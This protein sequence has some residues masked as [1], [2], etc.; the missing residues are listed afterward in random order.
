MAQDET[1]GLGSGPGTEPG[2]AWEPEDIGL[3][4]VPEGVPTGDQSPPEKGDR[5]GNVESEGPMV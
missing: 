1:E 4:E 2:T 5:G 3:E